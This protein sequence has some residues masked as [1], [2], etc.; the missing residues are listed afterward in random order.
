[1]TLK[2]YRQYSEQF[3]I[4][5]LFALNDTGTRGS[6]VQVVSFSGKTPVAWSTDLAPGINGVYSHRPVVPSKVKLAVS[7]A[8]GDVI[9][10]LL[11][12]VLEYNP[13]DGRAL[14]FS[15]TSRR[16]ELQCVISGEA[17]PIVTKGFFEVK[18][19]VGTP[20]PGSGVGVSNSGAGIMGVLG[21]DTT[22]VEGRVGTYLT[23][24]G[25]DGSAL[26]YLDI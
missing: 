10:M 8:K 1:M 11:Y 18:G 7:G 17:V 23:P 25:A 5:G 19:F 26:I 22:R 6:L 14:I 15:D 12:D 3:V 20:Q 13:T 24:T 2:P 9:G 4:N 21:K 16:D